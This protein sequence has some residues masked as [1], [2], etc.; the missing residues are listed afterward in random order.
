MDYLTSSQRRVTEEAKFSKIKKHFRQNRKSPVCEPF[1]TGNQDFGRENLTYGVST[2]QELYPKRGK[3][4]GRE[5]I[6]RNLSRERHIDY[7]LT[8]SD[9]FIA[10]KC[11]ISS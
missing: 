11:V 9:L 8:A 5:R 4:R 2:T 6:H 10:C 7:T 3:G 1:G